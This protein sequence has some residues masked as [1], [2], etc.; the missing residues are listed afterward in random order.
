[1]NNR[2]ALLRGMLGVLAVT[3]IGCTGERR[4]PVVVYSP[5][6][7]EMLVEFERL[8]E[9]E[10]PDQDMQWLDM[11]SQDVYDRIRTERE[12]PQA[13]IWWGAPMTTFM[14]A[15]KEGL[16]ERYI[17]GWDTAVGPEFK[18][19]G[20]CWYATFVAPEVI[21]FN[22]RVVDSASAP[23]DWD[24]LLDP[25][26]KDKIVIR[27][28]LASGTMRM[29]F[30]ALIDRERNRRGR[31]DDGFDWLR[32]LD[33]NTKTYAADPTQLYVKIARE[34][35]V[36]SVWN[37]PDVVIQ[38]TLNHYPFGYLIPRN[39]T[40]L[41]TDAIALVK[42]CKHPE[43]AR[44]FYEYVT[45][46]PSMILQAEKYFR[47]PARNDIRRKDLPPWIASLSVKPLAVNWDT[48]SVR[49]REW[50]EAWDGR[51]KGQG[52]NPLP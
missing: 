10:H 2:P 11:G 46:V 9:A 45:S 50:M 19:A 48:L 16:L 47:I 27:S 28:P 8:Y 7:K 12:N 3:V 42:G 41:I 5:H 44:E 51:V 43:P 26:W 31:L 39:G 38:T 37:L 52:R 30:C 34:E 32:R 29:I 25:R 4:T 18:S 20:G 15:E 17:P 36:V 40:P 24:E 23:S 13:D 33:A 6:G 22:N 21:M 49:E 35:G 14:R 1:M